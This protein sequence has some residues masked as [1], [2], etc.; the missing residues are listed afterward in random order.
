MEL[1]Y[2]R[3]K[4]KSWDSVSGPSEVGR[5]GRLKPPHFLCLTSDLWPHKSYIKYAKTQHVQ[6]EPAGADSALLSILDTSSSH[7]PSIMHD[8]EWAFNSVLCLRME[9]FCGR[10]LTVLGR[11]FK[12][13]ARSIATNS[14]TE[15]LPTL[16]HLPMALCLD[17]WRTSMSED[18]KTASFNTTWLRL[19]Q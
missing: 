15:S 14:S 18:C 13:C 10:G 17:T 9:R 8:H 7:S 4:I 11:G 2:T 16:E 3:I 6:A 19:L 12:F 1:I 5:Q